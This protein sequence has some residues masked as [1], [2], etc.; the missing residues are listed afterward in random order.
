MTSYV[1][2]YERFGC[3]VFYEV[4]ILY[5]ATLPINHWRIICYSYLNII[6][7]WNIWI[8]QQKWVIIDIGGRLNAFPVMHVDDIHDNGDGILLSSQSIEYRV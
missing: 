1:S 5:D 3:D 6:L 2:I 8:D 4:L 7:K